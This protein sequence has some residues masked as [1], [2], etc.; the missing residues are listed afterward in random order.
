MMPRAARFSGIVAGLLVLGMT[1]AGC[2]SSEPE[3]SGATRA[4]DWMVVTTA[5][6]HRT[7][8]L[9]ARLQAADRADLAF[10]VSG[11][12]ERVEVGLGDR[13]EAGDRLASVDPEPFEQQLRQARAELAVAEAELPAAEAQYHR[14]QRLVAGDARTERDLDLSRAAFEKARAS[15][16]RAQ[17][18]VARAERAVRDTVLTAPFDGRVAEHPRE[19]GNLVEPGTPVVHLVSD[20]RLELEAVVSGEQAAAL[21]TGSRHVFRLTGL[22]GEYPTRLT[23]KA[24]ATRQAGGIA[25]RFAVENPPPA[26]MP[27]MAVELDLTLPTPQPVRIPLSAL[28]SPSDGTGPD[29]A[30]VFVYDPATGQVRRRDIRIRHPGG[31]RVTV[32]SGLI[33]GEIIARRG[34]AFL[35]DGMAV[36]LLGQGPARFNP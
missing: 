15:V 33:G 34:V 22:P 2:E 4:I 35:E 31:E 3:T 25:L 7:L 32:V 6:A 12:L 27:G 13:V 18:A 9:P 19:P 14:D 24:A 17:A 8:P 36:T 20:G 5:T 21:E 28:A 1:A 26:A 10:E 30:T 11:R 16:A 29:R 23:G